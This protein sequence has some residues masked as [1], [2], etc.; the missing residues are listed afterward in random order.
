[1]S[2]FIYFWI[3]KIKKARQ[4]ELEGLLKMEF[5]P[6][7]TPFQ[8]SVPDQYAEWMIETGKQQIT[9]AFAAGNNLY[10]RFEY[11]KITNNNNKL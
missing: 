6:G 10:S 9:L 5:G 11:L 2:L 4:R 8:T 3:L 1:M 7:K